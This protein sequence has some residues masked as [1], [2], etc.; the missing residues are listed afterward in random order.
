MHGC[1]L[2]GTREVQIV[3]QGRPP[4][5]KGTCHKSA[6]VAVWKSD[7]VV[8][9]KK[10]VNKIEQSMAEFVERRASAE[11]NPGGRTVAGTQSLAKSEDC[12]LPGYVKRRSGWHAGSKSG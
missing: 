5:E 11:R 12:G 1:V 3:G 4:V 2:S 8:V 7:E 6:G 9:V 10:R